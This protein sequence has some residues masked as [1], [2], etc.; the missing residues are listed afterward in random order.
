MKND[1][2]SFKHQLE[3]QNNSCFSSLNKAITIKDKEI[4]KLSSSLFRSKNK[5]NDLK[6]EIKDL[7]NAL[8]SAKKTIK[9]L[10][11]I[12]FSKDYAIIAYNEGICSFNPGCIDSNIE[13]TGHYEVNSKDLWKRLCY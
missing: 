3:N 5:I 2:H 12:I 9:S 6:S 13:P 11:D 1:T 7:R 10:D 4:C 8:S